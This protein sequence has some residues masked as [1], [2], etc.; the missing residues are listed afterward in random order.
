QERIHP[1]IDAYS[2]ILDSDGR[3]LTQSSP[4]RYVFF[5]NLSH[6][7]IY[8]S[9]VS[10][11]SF[12]GQRD[13]KEQ[14][15]GK[16]R[17]GGFS[18]N[19]ELGVIAIGEIPY[20]QLLPAFLGIS[21]PLAI[22]I[23]I[24]AIAAGFFAS[25]FNYGWIALRLRRMRRVFER[26]KTGKIPEF[27]PGK[28]SKDEFG[29]AFKSLQ[30][31]CDFLRGWITQQGPMA[32]FSRIKDPEIL[33]KVQLGQLNNLGEKTHAAVLHCHLHGLDALA[34]QANAKKLLENLN[35]F[36]ENVCQAVEGENGIVD[37][38]YDGSIVAF[39]GVPLA[40]PNDVHRAVRACMK[41]REHVEQL[42]L[43]LIK[44]N[45]PKIRAGIGLHYGTVLVG[46]VGTKD[47]KEYLAPFG[48]VEITRH[49]YQ[50][51][52]GGKIYVPVIRVSVITKK[53]T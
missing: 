14:P 17:I 15:G 52:F 39:W 32:K 21:S 9:A 33:A 25:L 8:Q 49:V 18:K 35:L 44:M 20:S 42:N 36:N 23:G 24:M 31:T 19:P 1:H 29:L 16:S 30:E 34:A 37:R 51:S 13:F 47:K 40:S 46:Q 28:T 7:A 53:P 41:I 5:E 45:V 12:Q 50:D 6:L 3:L 38:I 26:L 27:V 10:T 2:F 4:F 48:V 22:Q 11:D 43:A